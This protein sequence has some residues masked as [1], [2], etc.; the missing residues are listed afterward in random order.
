MKRSLYIPDTLY[1]KLQE[2][3]EKKGITVS[4]LIKI[5]CSDYIEKEEKKDK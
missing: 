3:A 2:I 5:A 4:A 1:N